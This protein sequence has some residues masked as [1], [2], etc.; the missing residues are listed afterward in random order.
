MYFRQGF[1]LTP[2]PT[3]VPPALSLNVSQSEC[4]GDSGQQRTITLRVCNTGGH[5]TNT[6]TVTFTRDPELSFCG[7]YSPSG[8]SISTAGSVDTITIP[9]VLGGA[10]LDIPICVVDYYVGPAEIGSVR[11]LSAV[12]NWSGGSDSGGASITAGGSCVYVSPT[13]TRTLTPTPTQPA[14]TPTFTASPTPA[15]PTATPTASPSFT[16]T[17]SFTHSPTPPPSP[18]MTPTRTPT[19]PP[20][21]APTATVTPLPL[22]LT[23]KSPNPSPAKD[24][25]W[26]PYVISTAAEVD[27]R[28]FDVSGEKILD[29][30]PLF[31]QAG[32]H[33]RRWDLANA[34]G[35][36][37]AS[38]VYLCRIVATAPNGDSDDAWVKVAVSR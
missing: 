7:P 35:A 5:L 21:P 9:S 33:E 12:L 22:L 36:R 26:L 8:Y 16:P 19:L 13:I 2:A 14:D 18:T 15:P 1:G 4:F 10:C 34:A 37:V 30:G 31:Q 25:V 23:P 38:G 20:T 11:L 29:L 17:P 24:A 6:A 32:V 27:I 28:V 3:P